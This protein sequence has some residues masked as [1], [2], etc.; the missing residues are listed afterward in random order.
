MYWGG[1]EVIPRKGE[2]FKDNDDHIQVFDK[3]KL[4]KNPELRLDCIECVKEF[5]QRMN[6][7]FGCV[8]N[9][10][11]HDLLIELSELVQCGIILTITIGWSQILRGTNGKVMRTIGF[12]SSTMLNWI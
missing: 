2:E 6:A 8:Y 10:W 1:M 3:A 7:I 11:E 12:A 4:S 9:F 5:F